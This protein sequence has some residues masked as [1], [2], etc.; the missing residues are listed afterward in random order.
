MRAFT[1]QP[2]NPLSA[3]VLSVRSTHA[4]VSFE[5]LEVYVDAKLEQLEDGSNLWKTTIEDVPRHPN[6]AEGACP[7][8]AILHV[9]RGEH[10]KLLGTADLGLV[11]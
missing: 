2:S 4:K 11:H 9:T 8:R 7:V 6:C 3:E 5:P 10:G 1:F